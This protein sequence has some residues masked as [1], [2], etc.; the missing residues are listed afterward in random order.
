MLEFFNINYLLE[1]YGYVGIFT[2]VFLESGIF[3]ALPGDSL[4]FTVG[5]FAASGLLNI[6]FVIFLIFISTFFGAVV[7]YE[8]GI[9][10]P[11]LQKF[12]FFRLI[13][14]QKNIDKT[15]L[16]FEKYGKVAILF[17]RFV[18]LMRT[19]TPIGAGIARMDYFLFLKYNLFG[20]LL[21]SIVVTLFGYI[22][23]NIFPKIQDYMSHWIAIVILLSIIPI[24]IEI[25]KN[26]KS[27]NK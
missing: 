25:W 1:T 12:S 5:L 4:L 20:S 22:L 11:N 15:H 14:K 2:I 10:L 18:P 7:G 21:W 8:I 19:F 13:L 26:K 24:F 6:Y 3:F 16:F 23:G 9:Y 27:K 17:S